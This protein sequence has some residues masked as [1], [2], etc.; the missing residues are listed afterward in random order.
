MENY[1]KGK[2]RQLIF[3][4]DKNY[5]IGII[6]IKETNDEEMQDFLNKT[7]TF[8]GYFAELNQEDNY[9]FKGKLEYND[10]YGYQY[11]VDNYERV[12]IKGRDAII[13]FLSSPLVKGCG[14]ASAK[15]IVD[16]L[17]DDAIKLIKEDIS[18]LYLVPKM[19]EKKAIKIYESINKYQ[20]TDD[21]IVE[22]KKL[23]LSI[24]EALT[25]INHFGNSS[26]SIMED[27][28]YSLKDLIDFKKIDLAYLKSTNF[29][30]NKRNLACIEQTFV[31][32]EIS[33]GN[34]YF[35]ENEILQ[36]LKD[37]FKIVL[38]YKSFQSYLDELIF[39]GTLYQEDDKLFLNNT[40]YMEDYISNRLKEI[41]SYNVT[42][43]K[44][45]D[46]EIIK[47]Q[48]KIDVT[49][50]EEQLSAI[51]S[52]LESR[53]SIITGGPGTGKTT[54]IKAIT[55][56][57]SKLHNLSSNEIFS[58]IAL[59]APTGRASKKLSEATNLPASTIH[60][61]L[62]WNKETNEFQ[63]NE[64]NPNYHK[65]IIIDETS[66][67]DT[68]LFYSLLKGLTR[69]IQ[70]V[71]VGDANQ[72]PSVGPGL[73]LN[74]LISSNIFTFSPLHQIYRQ[75]NNSYIPILASEI[76][77]KS[78]SDDFT[79][80]KDDYNFLEVSSNNIKESLKQ[81]CQ[82]CISK[83]LNEKDIQVLI[84][85]YKGENGIDNINSIL[86]NLFNPKDDNKNEI[87]IGDTIFRENDK[88]LQLV[89]DIDNNVFNGDIGYITSIISINH[90]RKTD[91][92]VIDF[93]GVKVEY[94]KEDMS[95][96]KHAYA[97]S[98]HKSQGSEFSHVIIPVSKNYNRMLY[99]KLIYTAVSRAKK[100][101][102]IIGDSNAFKMAIFNVYSSNRKT[103]LLNK[104]IHNY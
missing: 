50:N 66:M 15:S 12:Q 42:K 70:I 27:N 60:R 73:I 95:N 25:I 104:L 39:D 89:N 33:T 88:V 3:E 52:S 21:M 9:I 75:S 64:F 4:S 5:K 13:E 90:P 103:N 94:K 97:I 36:G 93:D 34:T 58:Q 81:I 2:V 46:T 78:L 101:L 85:I 86:Q 53:V 65:L 22:F 43:Y 38:D 100:S 69:N 1:I 30:V 68:F 55:N 7:I 24:N 20:T 48:E 82:M 45:F 63:V 26:L 61:F 37:Y 8:V 92:F 44:I 10:K 102:V 91:I 49:Y 29:D 80:K 77:D 18:N 56:L 16:T 40:Y 57:Y 87:K 54:I 31:Y 84:P 72:L 59:L 67:I 23:G 83:N 35:N 99:N 47:L 19:T 41:N 62:K 96:V 98:I 11:R 79:T 71:L 17:G 32:L 51:K 6:R 14:E 28:P 76:K 74:D